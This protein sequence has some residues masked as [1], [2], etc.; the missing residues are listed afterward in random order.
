MIKYFVAVCVINV[1]SAQTP[2]ISPSFAPTTSPTNSPSVSP[3]N[4]P[5]VSP[6]LKTSLPLADFIGYGYCATSNGE[7]YDRLWY[8][9]VPTDSKCSEMCSAT[10]HCVGLNFRNNYRRCFCFYYNDLVP[11]KD[12]VSATGVYSGFNA[13]SPIVKTVD[14]TDSENWCYKLKTVGTP[15][16][17]LAPSKS[18]TP[19][20]KSPTNP[21]NTLGNSPGQTPTESPGFSTTTKVGLIVIGAAGFV[22]ASSISVVVFFYIKDK[23]K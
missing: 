16:P 13:S 20:T 19:P 11:D 15:F 6:T 5:S 17:T 3:T 22:I 2:T 4:T 21:P 18:P 10:P 8:D 23:N 1:A 14:K 7:L 9:D 12:L